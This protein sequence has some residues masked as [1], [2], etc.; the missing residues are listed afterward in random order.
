MPRL[1]DAQLL[2][3]A[4]HPRGFTAALGHERAHVRHGVGQREERR[5][6]DHIAAPVGMRDLDLVRLLFELPFD[7]PWLDVAALSGATLVITALLGAAG[8]R[9][10]RELSPQAALLASER[11][12]TGAA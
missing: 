7:P 1:A 11:F 2:E 6:I 3:Q 8:V 5:A 12:G 10:S 9:H 4:P